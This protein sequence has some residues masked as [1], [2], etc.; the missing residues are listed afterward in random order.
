MQPTKQ[1]PPRPR[2]TKT[3]GSGTCPIVEASAAP[4][5][6]VSVFCVIDAAV[7]SDLEASLNLREVGVSFL[8]VRILFNVSY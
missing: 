8:D 2:R 1:R 4:V 7:R 3:D 6:M 5:L